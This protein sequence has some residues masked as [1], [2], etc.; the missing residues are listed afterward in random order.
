MPVATVSPLGRSLSRI[1]PAARGILALLWLAA[2]CVASVTR[3]V[4]L[5]ATAVVA[6]ALFATAKASLRA[7]ALR[8]VGVASFTVIAL[9]GLALLPAEPGAR[10]IPVVGGVSMPA[11]GL[12]FVIDIAL[13]AAL[14]IVFVGVL[15]RVFA[16]RELLLALNGLPLPATPRCLVYLSA[17][18]LGG[19]RQDLH[20]LFRARRARGR[21]TRWQAV[22]SSMGMLGVLIVRAGRAAERRAF[23]LEA[24]GFEDRFPALDDRGPRAGELLLAGLIGGVPLC[25]ASLC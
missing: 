11:E 13:R 12:V 6:A 15:A 22:R 8:M 3:P 23:A 19:L 20:R 4:G 10:A 21:I 18:S 7:A 17:T 14:L 1:G 16:P 5:I 24:R 2:A 25:L 9:A